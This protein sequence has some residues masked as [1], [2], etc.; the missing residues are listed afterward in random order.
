MACGADVMESLRF[1]KCLSN[2]CV[3]SSSGEFHPAKKKEDIRDNMLLC[4]FTEEVGG[5]MHAF[6]IRFGRAV[7]VYSVKIMENTK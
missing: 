6:R 2:Y 4:N 1:V 3:I 5:V 7:I